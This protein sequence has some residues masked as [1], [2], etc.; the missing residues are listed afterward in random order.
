MNNAILNVE[1]ALA[2]RKCLPFVRR[3]AIISG[4]GSLTYAFAL[5]ALADYDARR[6]QTEAVKN[7]VEAAQARERA[8][9]R[10]VSATIEHSKAFGYKSARAI[11]DRFGVR[12]VRAA[13]AS[14]H[15]GIERAMNMSPSDWALA[16]EKGVSPIQLPTDKALRA[17][18][19]ADYWRNRPAPN[20][21]EAKLQAARAV[22]PGEGYLPAAPPAKGCDCD[23]C[24]EVRLKFMRAAGL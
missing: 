24:T 8:L 6:V 12:Y 16:D 15:A 7:V 5:R 13:P 10:A 19:T 14:M 4:D 9:R 18:I 22:R 1:L 2:L 3:H 17:D 23:I 20:G 11:L 21:Y